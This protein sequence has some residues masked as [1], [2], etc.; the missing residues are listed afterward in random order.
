[1]SYYATELNSFN[2]S[3]VIVFVLVFHFV[4]AF[5]QLCLDTE[6]AVVGRDAG[7]RHRREENVICHEC[8]DGDLCNQDLC[9]REMGLCV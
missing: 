9:A 2:D 7:V 6:R 4:V 5:F 3:S 1:M 8:C